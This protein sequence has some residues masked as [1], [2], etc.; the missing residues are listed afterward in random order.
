M[1]LAVRWVTRIVD[2]MQPRDEPGDFITERLAGPAKR[3][4][5]RS[6]ASPRRACA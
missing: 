3:G 5:Q 1:L 6:Q 2:A 4:S